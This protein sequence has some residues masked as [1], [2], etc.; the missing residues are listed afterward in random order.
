MIDLIT[1]SSVVSFTASKYYTDYSLQVMV[2]FNISLKSSTDSTVAADRLL[3]LTRMMALVAPAILN[4]RST[5]ENVA[6]ILNRNVRFGAQIV[7][8]HI[9]SNRNMRQIA[10]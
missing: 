8:S 10:I 5:D 2:Y 1:L 4:T 7:D 6:E 9:E 3:R